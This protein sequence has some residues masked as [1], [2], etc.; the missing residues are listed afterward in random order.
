MILRF[1]NFLNRLAA[2]GSNRLNPKLYIRIQ[3]LLVH[4]ERRQIDLGVSG[5]NHLSQSEL[6]FDVVHLSSV[7]TFVP[8]GL[9]LH[10]T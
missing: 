1:R 2:K 4:K 3:G 8:V 7:P 10:R 6:F 5:A 9:A